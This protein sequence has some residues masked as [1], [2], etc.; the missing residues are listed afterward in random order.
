[1]A[2]IISISLNKED[3][4]YLKQDEL[5]SP[6]K[7]FQVALHNIKQNRQLFEERLKKS[8]QIRAMIQDKLLKATEILKSHG[9][10]DKYDKA[11]EV[12]DVL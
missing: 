12:K 8:E 10:I 3:Y 2:K 9:L 7:I 1:M 6:S 11:C 4:E 5:L